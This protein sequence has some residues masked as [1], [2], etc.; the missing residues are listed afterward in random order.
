MNIISEMRFIKKSLYP[1]FHKKNTPIS[2][3]MQ[4]YGLK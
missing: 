3:A 1:Y 2:E 4:A